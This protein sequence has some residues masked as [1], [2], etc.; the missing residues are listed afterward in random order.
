MT[1]SPLE[2]LLPH[3]RDNELR[4]GRWLV[5]IVVVL[6]LVHFLVAAPYVATQE[7][8]SALRADRERLTAVA[9]ELAALAPY[10]TGPGTAVDEVMGP[11]LERLVGDVRGDLVRLSATY[12]WL[13]SFVAKQRGESPEEGAASDVEIF[14]VENVDRILAVAEAATVEELLAALA[15][16][17]ERH[18]V[19]PRF[20]DL[21]ELWTSTVLPRIEAALDAVAASVPEL[22]GRLGTA[23]SPASNAAF[24]AFGTALAAARRAARDLQWQPPE[25][26]DWWTSAPPAEGELL[27]LRLDPAVEEQLRHPLALDQLEVVTSR[28]EETYRAL[29]DAVERRRQASLDGTGAGLAARRE[30]E[31]LV[32]GFPLVLGLALA[33]AVAA[34]GRRRR[35]LGLIV[36]LLVDRGADGL[37]DWYFRRSRWGLES[38]PPGRA[39]AA[40]ARAALLRAAGLAVLGGG[41]IAFAAYQLRALGP[42]LEAVVLAAIGAAVLLAAV[43]Y[44]ASVGRG[45]ARRLAEETPETTEIL[46]G[47]E[48]DAIEEG[49]ILDGHTLRR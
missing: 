49:G 41:W 47:E 30:T 29:V 20:S 16:E 18:V 9:D 43:I 1:S 7:R 6:G 12:D 17:A 26:H 44:D 8:R 27:S 42:P 13:R 32:R 35:E 48:L 37:A 10:V 4:A 5:S 14:R 24:D 33:A 34:A 36:H 22:R 23:A 28:V 39:P 25:R 11:A 45:I 31:L 3:A 40:A 2:S 21:Q 46:T 19:H 38:D 15:P